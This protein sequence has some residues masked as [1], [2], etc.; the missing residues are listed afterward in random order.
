MLRHL[1]QPELQ[2]LWNRECGHDER[3]LLLRRY[4]EFC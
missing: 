3:G 4:L 2:L 1:Q